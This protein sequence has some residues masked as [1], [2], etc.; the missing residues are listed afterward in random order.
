MRPK[1]VEEQQE[2][3]KTPPLSQQ[4]TG[5]RENPFSS[6]SLATAASARESLRDDRSSSSFGSSRVT[7]TYETR[8]QAKA[9]AGQD[10]T[11]RSKILTVRILYT[12]TRITPKLEEVRV[13][14]YTS[15]TSYVFLV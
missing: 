12:N 11:A 7:Q 13:H 5:E 1:Q 2:A 10:K 14:A 8:L 3:K 9:R 6:S 4:N 15:Y